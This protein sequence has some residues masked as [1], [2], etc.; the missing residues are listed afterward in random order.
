MIESAWNLFLGG[1]NKKK[2]LPFIA[3][4][5]KRMLKKAM[6]D[7]DKG[8][9]NIIDISFNDLINNR[10]KVVETLSSKLDFPITSKKA[11]KKKPSF[12]KNKFIYNPDDYGVSKYDIDGEFDFYLKQYSNYL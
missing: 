9:L 1:D 2:V 4:L 10:Q 7:R 11:K 3:N 5:Y 8:N 6:A 12:F